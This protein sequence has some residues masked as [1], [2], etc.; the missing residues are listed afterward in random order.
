MKKWPDYSFSSISDYVTVPVING[1]FWVYA[2]GTENILASTS[3]SPS[4]G[5]FST[6][7]F[8]G[9]S[10]ST[11]YSNYLNAVIF[12][13]TITPPASSR[14][15]LIRAFHAVPDGPSLDIRFNNMNTFSNLYYLDSSSYSNMDEGTYRVQVFPSGS[16]H[17]IFTQ[18]NIQLQGGK[19]YSLFIEGTLDSITA[20]LTTDATYH[21]YTLRTI[22]AALNVPFPVDVI[23]DG[24]KI[25]TGLTYQSQTHFQSILCPSSQVTTN[26]CNANVTVVS[27]TTSTPVIGPTM[28]EFSSQKASSLVVVGL[29]AQ[30]V[31]A[32]VVVDNFVPPPAGTSAS[33][34]FVHA[35]PNAGMVDVYS[36]GTAL[37]TNFNFTGV[38]N[39]ITVGAGIYDVTLMQSNNVLLSVYVTLLPGNVYTVYVEGLKSGIG[40]NA[41]RAEIVVDYV[42][43]PTFHLRTIHAAPTTS[44]YDLVMDNQIA[45]TSVSYSQATNYSA[46]EEGTYTANFTYAGTFTPFYST[47][48]QFKDAKLKYYSLIAIGLQ[49]PNITRNVSRPVHSILVEDNPDLPAEG[50]VKIRFI[51]VSPDAPALDLRDQDGD[52][53]RNISYKESTE[54][55]TK[56]AKKYSFSVF[57]NVGSEKGYV[58]GVD[59]DFSGGPSV[60]TIV[61][62]GLVNA[63]GGEPKFQLVYYRDSAHGPAPPSP[64][65]PKPRLSAWQLGLIIGGS[66]LAVLL[67][68][69]IGFTVYKKSRAGYSPIPSTD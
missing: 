17:P 57:P 21:Y 32:L 46:F 38:S 54:Y 58:E 61:A 29:Y 67:I 11:Q 49:H 50:S 4:A 69:V 68:S 45:F 25:W 26:G 55:F 40:M 16:S 2:Q 1:V 47:T 14:Q 44:T 53:F 6:A 22:H 36:N 42:A 63:H 35:S 37:V 43:P 12:P 9:L 64:A 28:I 8:V 65:A 39:Y 10:S 51:H 56:S 30:K 66:I 13:D 5:S 23:L 34:R 62:E 41:L 60:Y 15:A 52:V 3:L 59:F 48:L 7:A 27:S 18:D 20:L 33:V 31:E 24:Q 19:V